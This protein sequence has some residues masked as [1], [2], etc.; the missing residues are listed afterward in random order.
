MFTN[1]RNC[2]YWLE[3]LIDYE[4]IYKK[5][6]KT[7]LICATRNFSGLTKLN[8]I[9]VNF[10]LESGLLN[11]E[12]IITQNKNLFVET[13]GK[14]FLKNENFEISNKINLKT[15][16]L[17]QLPDFYIN[18]NG[19]S[20]KYKVSYNLDNIKKKLF[21]DTIKNILKKNKGK[22]KLDKN[23]L[24]LLNGSDDNNSNAQKLIDLFVR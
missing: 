2:F 20:K 8:I 24:D 1:S 14:Y 4:T 19:N 12:K 16:K 23:F 15:K 11:I 6:N 5:K 18:L 22:L 3:W 7:E 9:D 21:N 13:T 10:N 17:N